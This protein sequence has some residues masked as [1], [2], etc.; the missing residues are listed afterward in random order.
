MVDLEFFD[1]LM[2]PFSVPFLDCALDAA[3]MMAG[4]FCAGPG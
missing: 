1:E 3:E 4:S 2:L